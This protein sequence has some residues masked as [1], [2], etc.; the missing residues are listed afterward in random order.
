MSFLKRSLLT[1]SIATIFFFT[2]HAQNTPAQNDSTKQDTTDLLQEKARKQIQQLDKLIREIPPIEINSIEI[3]TPPQKD[4]TKQDSTN[5]LQEKARKQVQQLDKLIRE[6]P[7]I[8]INSIEIMTPSQKTSTTP[9]HEPI[10]S[11]EPKTLLWLQA[12]RSNS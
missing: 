9:S 7:P 2:A 3:I 12:V 6:I 10:T 11:I 4:S 5:L 8:E 1:A